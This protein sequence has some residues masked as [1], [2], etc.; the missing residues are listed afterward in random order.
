MSSTK[1][2]KRYWL[3][4]VRILILLI[5]VVGILKSGTP[6]SYFDPYGF[7]FVL[8]GG[9]ALVMIS[10]PGAEI[11]RAFRHAAG[12]PGSDAEIRNSIHFWEA[13]GR[14]FWIVGG[15]RS[16]L[17]IMIGFSAMKYEATAGMSSVIGFLAQSLLATF[18]GSLLAV[19]CFVPCWKL[20]GIM[21]SRSSAPNPERNE[22]PISTGRPGWRFGTVFGY[23][24]FLSA[25]VST[26]YMLNVDLPELLRV[27][28]PILLV[29]LGGILALMQFLGVNNS[30]LTLSTAFACMGSICSLMGFIQMLIGMTDPSPRGIGHVAGA[31]AFILSSCFITLLGMALAGAPLEDRA[32]R[33]GRVT[34][35]SAFSRVSWYVFPLLSLIFLILT[36]TM[37]VMP[38]PPAH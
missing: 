22:T 14:G 36:F 24:L 37:I 28:A 3:I 19:I 23:V 25:L 1:S 34:A 31:L 6:A 29:M 21:Q 12:R 33:I 13:A 26:S 30:R 9:V 8:V 15:L 32:I 4:P 27:C 16:V 5:V 20:L 18:Y 2:S 7:F 38:L 11:G 10:F 17:R 35:P